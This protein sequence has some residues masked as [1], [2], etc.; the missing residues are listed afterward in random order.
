MGGVVNKAYLAVLLAQPGGHLARH[1]KVVRHHH[2]AGGRADGGVQ[3][4][5]VQVQAAGSDIDKAHTGA[6]GWHLVGHYHAG[7]GRHQ[8]FVAGLYIV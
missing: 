5:P 8:H 4:Q 2:H 6:A 1:A 3:R 7:K